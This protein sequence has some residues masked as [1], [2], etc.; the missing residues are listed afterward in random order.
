MPKRLFFGVNNGS[1]DKAWVTDLDFDI[2]QMITDINLGPGVIVGDYAYFINFDANPRTVVKYDLD[3]FTLQATSSTG[4]D[5]EDGICT[6]GNYIFVSPEV[7]GTM[8]HVLSLDTLAKVGEGP[9]TGNDARDMHC[10]DGIVYGSD[11]SGDVWSWTPGQGSLNWKYGDSGYARAVYAYGDYVYFAN[12]G[13]YIKKLQV[14]NGSYVDGANL[15]GND[16]VGIARE[17]DGTH[18]YVNSGNGL[19]YTE[20]IDMGTMMV[21]ASHAFVGGWNKGIAYHGG[22]V[23]TADKGDQKILKIDT[24]N[25]VIADTFVPGWLFDGADVFL[26]FDLLS[27]GNALM[28]AANF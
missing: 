7:S 20:K 12:D 21:V 26:L 5:Y 4:Y 1:P 2:K 25:M 8:L 18:I 17:N 27:A 6:D 15:D 9:A 16:G 3:T 11:E 10:A 23:Y 14:S 24:S 19:E 13:G 22:Y 28:F